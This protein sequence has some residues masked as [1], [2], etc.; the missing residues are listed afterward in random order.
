MTERDGN[1]AWNARLARFW[2]SLAG[3]VP[4]GV[5]FFALDNPVWQ[6][7]ALIGFIGLGELGGWLLER[8]INRQA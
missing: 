2:V 1:A 4:G 6:S 8:A 5:L 7:I 3:I